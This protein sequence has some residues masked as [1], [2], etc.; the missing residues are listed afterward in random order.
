MMHRF[1]YTATDDE[2]LLLRVFRLRFR[3]HATGPLDAADAAII[4]DLANRYP[5]DASATYA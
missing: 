1:G 5:V 4:T 2:D 3:P